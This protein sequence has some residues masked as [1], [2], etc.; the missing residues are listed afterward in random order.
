ML[1]LL[2]YGMGAMSVDGT[3]PRFCAHPGQRVI[4]SL[5]D[6]NEQDWL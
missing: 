6:I 2:K 5:H 3:D 1:R 4:G